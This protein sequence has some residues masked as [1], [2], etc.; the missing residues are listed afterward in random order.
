M[1]KQSS[2][3]MSGAE[4]QVKQRAPDIKTGKQLRCTRDCDMPG[5]GLF[6]SGDLVDDQRAVAII[7][8]NPNFEEVKGGQS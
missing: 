2:K 7:A 1:K 5:I 4:P 6:R 8:D 3:E